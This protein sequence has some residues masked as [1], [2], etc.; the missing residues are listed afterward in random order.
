MAKAIPEPY[1][2]PSTAFSN[3]PTLAP[4][5][6]SPELCIRF[7]AFFKAKV[8]DIRANIVASTVAVTPR[9]CSPFLNGST[10]CSFDEVTTSALL[11]IIS[12]SKPTSCSLDPI[13]TP[14]L[15]ACSTTVVQLLTTLINKSLQTGEVPVHF[16]TAV[17]TPL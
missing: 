13:P 15:K 6:A 16:K 9:T 12:K 7:S 1:S 14:L 3:P 17:V 5:V 8:A 11:A 4:K 2:P 10:L